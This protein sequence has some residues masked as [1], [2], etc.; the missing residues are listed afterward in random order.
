M[1]NTEVTNKSGEHQEPLSEQSI[2]QDG[3]PAGTQRDGEK[4][5]HFTRSSSS[6]WVKCNTFS[7]S[8]CVPAGSPSCEIDCSDNGSWCSPLLFVTSVLPI[9]SSGLCHVRHV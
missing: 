1:G 2:S 6:D 8:L 9:A 5:L 4:V 3:E 7:P